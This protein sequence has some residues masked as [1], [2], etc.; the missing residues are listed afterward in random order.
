MHNFLKRVIKCSK[1]N[2]I[3]IPSFVNV[4]ILLPD[5]NQ[6]E[7]YVITKLLKFLKLKNFTEVKLHRYRQLT[8]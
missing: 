4:C 2:E 3:V 6:V 1:I 5:A 8:E 7:I